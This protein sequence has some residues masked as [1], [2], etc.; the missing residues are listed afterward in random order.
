MRKLFNMVGNMNIKWCKSCGKFH[1]KYSF[2]T[3]G[4]L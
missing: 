1:R 2:P 3:L 4:F